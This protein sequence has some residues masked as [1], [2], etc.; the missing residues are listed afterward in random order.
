M[1]EVCYISN[2]QQTLNNF[3]KYQ[4]FYTRDYISLRYF[5]KKLVHRKSFS[6]HPFFTTFSLFLK[7]SEVC[8]TSS[9]R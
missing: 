5:E 7:I 9:K 4:Y 6:N 1:A 2:K 3:A 8:N